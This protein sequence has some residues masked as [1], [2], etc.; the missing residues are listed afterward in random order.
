MKFHYNS[1]AD[2]T[3]ALIAMKDV[4]RYSDVETYVP[5][6]ISRYYVFYKNILPLIP[7]WKVSPEN[8]VFPSLINKKAFNGINF[9]GFF[10]DIG[11][12]EDYLFCYSH[13]EY[14]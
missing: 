3:V 4:A 11:V 10:I 13:P 5:A 2:A 1:C 12:P 14:L 9:D 8:V 6:R 7:D